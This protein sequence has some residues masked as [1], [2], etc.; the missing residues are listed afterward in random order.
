[1]EKEVARSVLKEGWEVFIGGKLLNRIG[2]FALFLGVAF[3]LKYAFDHK[4]ITETIRVVL[5]GLGGAFL[6]WWGGYFHRKGLNIFAQGLVGGGIAILYVSV[7]AAYHFYGLVPQTGALS[8]MMMVTLVAIWQALRYDSLAVSLLGWLGGFLTPFLLQGG[9]GGGLGV[10]LYTA[11]LA[12][13]LLGVYMK[14]REWVA[15][16]VMTF[17]GIS[18]ITLAVADLV[19]QTGLLVAF[20]ILYW[21]FFFAVDAWCFLSKD[22]KLPHRSWHQAVT[23][24]NALFLAIGLY[25]TLEWSGI[26]LLMA[27]VSYM[28]LSQRIKTSWKQVVL[29]Y[30]WIAAV[31][32]V[33]G[34]AIHFS[35]EITL[36]LWALEA[37]IMTGYGLIRSRTSGWMAGVSLM[38]LTGLI[39]LI[40]DWSSGYGFSSDVP[41]LNLRA[42]T[43]VLLAGVA[44]ITA[45]MFGRENHLMA[46]K[47]QQGLHIGW[48][49]LLWFGMTGEVSRIYFLVSELGNARLAFYLVIAW[50]LYALLLAGRMKEP[51]R[52]ALGW[53]AL[54]S[55]ALATLTGM[56]WGLFIYTPLD[57]FVPLLNI[58]SGALL[59]LLFLLWIYPR[60][61]VPGHL[62]PLL[63]LIAAFLMMIL[64][65]VEPRDSFN[66]ALEGAEPGSA[67]FVL[68]N[69]KRISLSG[70]WLLYSLILMGMGIWKKIS[71][72]RWMSILLFGITILK[73]F[74]WDLSFL[75]TL[76]RIFSFIGL[77]LVLLGVSYLYQRYKH[78]FK[79]EKNQ[80]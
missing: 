28:V 73:V 49:V 80:E 3:F 42:F 31:L 25:T 1:M 75:G 20:I 10:L 57:S 36:V 79:L 77:G 6:L 14:K 76:Y 24:L 7:F 46:S 69:M 38:V 71:H 67:T 54:G 17:G 56:V 16:Y 47:M 23:A 15:L 35:W 21:L 2:A 60:K 29:L 70:S 74:L 62:V 19:E 41:F 53:V 52:R 39:L 32:I 68:D 66:R 9:G 78:R 45:W 48:S 44:I 22:R 27:S 43:Y 4:W 37:M 50:S 8:L 63:P 40:T 13:G 58:R 61:A 55:L 12:L 33:L 64:V 59:L 5:G 18:F 26:A 34:T 72:L 11:I 51:D 65:T 30:E